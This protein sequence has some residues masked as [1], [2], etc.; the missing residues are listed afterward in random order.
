MKAN[1]KRVRLEMM[2]DSLDGKTRA[3]RANL[4]A[5]TV[6]KALH[7]DSVRPLTI[8]RIARV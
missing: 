4:P 2:R 1:K 3:K 5:K 6:Y 7:G 8:A